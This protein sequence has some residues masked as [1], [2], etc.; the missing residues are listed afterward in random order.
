MLRTVVAALDAQPIVFLTVIVL[1]AV[2]V[3]KQKIASAAAAAAQNVPGHCKLLGR[4]RGLSDPATAGGNG[5][6]SDR[7][8]SSQAIVKHMCYIGKRAVTVEEI[9]KLPQF[10]LHP[11]FVIPAKAGIQASL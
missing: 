4:P 3:V 1:L 5:G 6:P 2:L 9:A 7:F 10:P 11:S 8:G